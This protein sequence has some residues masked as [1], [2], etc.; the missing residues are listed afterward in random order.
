MPSSARIFISY[1]REDTAAYAAHLYE[2]LAS[3]FGR[4]AVF[5]DVETIAPGEAFAE[6]IESVMATTTAVIVLIGRRWLTPRLNDDDDFVRIEVETA[7]AHARE[8]IPVLVGGAAMPT[9]EQ[10]EKLPS[11]LPLLGHQ[12]YAF[13]WHE[14]VKVVGGRIA[15]V[16]RTRKAEEA[17]ARKEAERLDLMRGI[18][19]G[20]AAG[21]AQRTVNVV[22][23]AMELSLRRQGV[24]RVRLSVPDLWASLSRLSEARFPGLAETGA[25]MFDDLIRVIDFT[26]VKSARGKRRYVARSYPLKDLDEV[27]GHILLGRPVLAGILV[28]ASWFE[29]PATTEG[30][31]GLPAGDTQRGGT[32]VALYGWDPERAVVSFLSPW[33]GWGDEG[34][35]HVPVDV[36]RRLITG[37]MRSIEVVAMP[38]PEA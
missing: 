37:Q 17:A 16:E 22:T 30:R 5:R 21:G 14:D 29:P 35:G 25:F 7:L 24:K 32:V 15:E 6:V 28:Y 9:E 4:A 12:A 11:L 20:G 27:R 18:E 26:G 19:L 10:L 2:S 13:R 38:D 3:R 34:R 36:A 33:P 23:Q 8:V 31:I 1:R